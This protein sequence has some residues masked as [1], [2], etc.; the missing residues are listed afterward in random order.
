MNAQKIAITIPTDLVVWID[1]VS[2]RSGISRSGFIAE[3]LLE[4]ISEQKKQELKEAYDSVFSDESVCRNR[5]EH[6]HG[7]KIAE[8]T[9]GRNGN[10]ERE[11]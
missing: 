4:K 11:K 10:K 8:M 9:M 1:N 3:V 7:L 6:R 5:S 2:K